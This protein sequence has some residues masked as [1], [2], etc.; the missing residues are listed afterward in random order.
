MPESPKFLYLNEQYDEVRD[1]LQKMSEFNGKKIGTN[2]I[3]EKEE[4]G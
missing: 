2:Y 3:F 1:I 4:E